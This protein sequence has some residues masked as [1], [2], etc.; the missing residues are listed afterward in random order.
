[1]K[2]FI[3]N[4][5]VFFAVIVLVDILFGLS[6]KYMMSHTTGG[7]TYCQY[8]TAKLSDEDIIMLGSS[9]MRHH[10]NPDLIEDSLNMTCFNSGEDGSGIIFNYGLYKM[11]T[12]RYTPKIIIYDLFSFDLY[13]DDNIKYL[14][15]LRKFYDEPGIK[16]II[17]Y[18]DKK[19]QIKCIS[20]MYRYNTRCIATIADYLH[21]VRTYHKGYSAMAGRLDFEPDTYEYIPQQLDTVKLH[22][23]D[24]L[25]YDCNAKNIELV[26]CASPQYAVP[27]DNHYYDQIAEYLK[28]KDVRF[29]NH[30][31]C[32]EI[33][34]D[35][36][37][38]SD[39][40]HLNSQ[41]ADK[42]TN[43]LISEI[44]K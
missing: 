2:R 20:S 44:R 19:E 32:G 25:I 18:V 23:L 13:P 12:A 4:I 28:T 26:F 1:M 34:E 21:P 3:C 16:D 27:E 31:Y 43:L 15:W 38:F 6:Q 35:R 37:L 36:S 11:L 5:L 33:S 10:Y 24:L 14:G 9:R 30:F 22:F 7:Q 8:Y 40:H 17:T 29:L 39:Q 41:G 42:F